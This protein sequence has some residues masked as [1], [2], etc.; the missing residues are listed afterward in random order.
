LTAL[1]QSWQSISSGGFPTADVEAGRALYDTA[2]AD[3]FG[4]KPVEP[5]SDHGRGVGGCGDTVD[6]GGW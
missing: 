5:A 6:V 3:A 1:D 4:G 2:L